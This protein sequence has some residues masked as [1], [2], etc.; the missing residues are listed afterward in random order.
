MIEPRQGGARILLVEDHKS[1]ARQIEQALAQ[2]GYSPLVAAR[3]DQAL[4]H[5]AAERLDMV[6]LDV[7]L[8][9]DED[10]GYSLC[11]FIRRGGV[12]GALAA[13]KHVPIIM[14]TSRNEDEE[15]QAGYDAGADCYLTKPFRMSELLDRVAELLRTGRADGGD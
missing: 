13:V 9:R 2:E 12:G 4:E 15:R 7:M 3:D 6:I 11:K 10:A 14:I 8:P 5:L 1:L